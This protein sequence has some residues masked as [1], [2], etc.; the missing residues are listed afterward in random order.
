MEI[1]IESL[2]T[3]DDF[4][5]LLITLGE[6]AKTLRQTRNLFGMG[7]SSLNQRFFENAYP[8]PSPTSRADHERWLTA[9][10]IWAERSNIIS[11][12]DFTREHATALAMEL[13]ENDVIAARRFRFYRRVWRTTGLDESIWKV[14]EALPPTEH[15]H[16]RRLTLREVRR[17]V[18]NA[19]QRSG[20]L[21]D[22]IVIG[23]STGLR[24]SDVSE[25]EKGEVILNRHAL[26]LIPNK[27][28]HRKPHPL[29]IPL[30]Q[31]A[32][33]IIRPRMANLSANDQYLFPDKCR[34]HSSRQL[35]TMFR[36]SKINKTGTGRASFHSLRATFISMMDEA[37]IQPYITD[38]ITGH[39]AGG[40]H[41]RYTQ[42]A[43]SILRRAVLK[44]IPRVRTRCPRP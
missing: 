22:M 8:P 17:L 28:R 4:L 42:P 5:S 13:K 12:T 24:L 10:R 3:T 9:L 38:A 26:Q 35:E 41:A 19:Q 11:P 7:W 36:A 14:A 25:L 16:Y 1:N 2:K 31:E 23:Y 32:E 20:D 30:T 29:L 6:K 27:V 15:E 21:A 40:M 37:G 34:Q 18:K 39:A 44:A 43:L 33:S